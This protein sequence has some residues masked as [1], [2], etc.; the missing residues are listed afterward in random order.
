MNA[1]GYVDELVRE[2]LRTFPSRMAV[3]L[4]A[5][6]VSVTL[7]CA[8]AAT[9][10]ECFGARTLFPSSLTVHIS[11]VASCGWCWRACACYGG[12]AC[13]CVWWRRCA[14]VAG[15][16]QCGAISPPPLRCVACVFIRTDSSRWS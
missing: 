2:Y 5:R 16:V 15:G 6:V 1:V 9:L 14:V 8:R 13:V 12:V 4:R 10:A 11:C 7:R 3:Q